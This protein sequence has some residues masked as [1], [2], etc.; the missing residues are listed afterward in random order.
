MATDASQRIPGAPNPKWELPKVRDIKIRRTRPNPPRLKH[1]RSALT[2]G[3]E[4]V[5]FTVKLDGP[6]PAR[7]LGPALFVGRERVIECQAV[8]ERTL[9]FVATNPKRLKPGVGIQW[10][11]LDALPRQ[12]AET[13]F[14]F[15]EPK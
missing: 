2:D 11:W 7:A 5:E 12:R 1:L 6:V 8:D 13:K 3:D 4:V 14:K 15:V 9:R 10:G